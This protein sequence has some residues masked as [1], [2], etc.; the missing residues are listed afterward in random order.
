LLFGV[1]NIEKFIEAMQPTVGTIFFTSRSTIR[2]SPAA[3]YY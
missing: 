3:C 2:G 1:Y